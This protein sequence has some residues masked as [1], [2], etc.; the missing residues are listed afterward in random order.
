MTVPTFD[1]DSKLIRQ[2]LVLIMLYVTFICYMS[3][4]YQFDII[5]TF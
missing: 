3:F 2:M 1:F 5:L 4:G